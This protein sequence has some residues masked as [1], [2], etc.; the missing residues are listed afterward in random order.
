MHR[1][2]ELLAADLAPK[3]VFV[4]SIS[5]GLVQDR[6]DEPLPRRR[7]VDAAGAARR[8]SCARS[9][10][11]SSTRSPAATCM[12]STIRPRACAAGSTEILEQD[13]NAIRLRA[14]RHNRAAMRIA[15]A[16]INP[17]VGDLAGNRAIILERL[18][19]AK[20]AGADPSSSRAA[21]P[22]TRRRISCCGPAS[23][24]PP[25]RR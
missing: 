20:A 17:V 21:V 9:P 10:P 6:D 13:L 14:D 22:A 25:R 23:S 12:P 7:A 11:A 1:F 4:F 3:N 8:G 16:Q 19:K 18:E 15:L 5:P 2:S 24:A